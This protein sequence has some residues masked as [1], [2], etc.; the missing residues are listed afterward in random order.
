GA[1]T[2]GCSWW[3]RASSAE[4]RAS[5]TWRAAAAG[6]RV[7]RRARFSPAGTPGRAPAPC[8]WREVVSAPLRGAAP[9]IGGAETWGGAGGG[10][11]TSRATTYRHLGIDYEKATIP[12]FTGRPIPIVRDGKPIPGLLPG[13]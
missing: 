1:W 5:P 4:R 2:S 9:Q 10:P 13:T 3:S 6:W 7:G 11:R 8:S 12:D